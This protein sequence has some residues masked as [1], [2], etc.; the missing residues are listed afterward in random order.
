MSSGLVYAVGFNGEDPLNRIEL[1][2]EEVSRMRYTSRAQSL[3][4]LYRVEFS[5]ASSGLLQIALWLVLCQCGVSPNHFKRKFPILLQPYQDTFSWHYTLRSAWYLMS[6]SLPSSGASD[7]GWGVS[8]WISAGWSKNLEPE[9]ALESRL[10]SDF[11]ETNCFWF[12]RFFS[13]PL[14][15]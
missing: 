9:T 2:L 3:L 8:S 10:I 1:L 13:T 15:F 11:T 14:F 4:L 6:V 7:S 12:Y 5:Y